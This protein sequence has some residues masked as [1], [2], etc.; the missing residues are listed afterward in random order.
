M[1]RVS[2]I[3]YV[4]SEKNE[5]THEMEDKQNTDFD[6]TFS[7]WE[8]SRGTNSWL[9]NKQYHVSGC[10]RVWDLKY[11]YFKGEKYNN[12]WCKQFKHPKTWTR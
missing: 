6:G 2:F 7:K 4:N 9:Q 11:A 12:K 3:K 1:V 8:H 10:Q 5:S